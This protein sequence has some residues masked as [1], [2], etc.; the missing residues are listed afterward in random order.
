MMTSKGR[1]ARWSGRWRPRTVSA[2]TLIARGS[3]FSTERV[4]GYDAGEIVIT[5]RSLRV[6]MS[7]VD[8]NRSD[9]DD[10][11]TG[12]KFWAFLGSANMPTR[13][14]HSWHPEPLQYPCGNAG[15]MSESV[16][17]CADCVRDGDYRN[18]FQA[19]THLFVIEEWGAGVL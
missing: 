10:V 4:Y 9:P 18:C 11:L 1:P 15:E 12:Q 14:S 2:Q 13:A 5:P 19:V 7:K 8:D 17:V 16:M 6:A 3:E